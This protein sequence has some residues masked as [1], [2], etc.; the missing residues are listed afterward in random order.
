MPELDRPRILQLCAVDFTVWHFLMPLMR[1]QR[2]W[3]FDVHV[4]CTAGPFSERIE[5]EGFRLHP[6]SIR[7]SVNPAAH[8]K[9]YRALRRLLGETS[10]QMVHVHTPVAALIGRPAARR[11]GVPVVVY[12]AHGFY[13]HDRMGAMKRRV[14]IGLERWAQR[15]CDY[16]MTQSAE[17]C[18]TAIE[19]RI[20]PEA[21]AAVIGN[22]VD[23]DRFRPGGLD[24]AQ[25]AE[26]LEGLGIDPACGPIV[27]MMG[28]LVAEK[29]YFEFLEAWSTLIEEFPNARAI[30]IGEALQSDR[31]DSARAIGRRIED[32][33]L[34]DSIC[35]AGLR[36]DVPVLMG[37]SDLFVLPSWR[38][39]MP[40]SIIE[41]MASGAPVIATD[42]RGCREEVVDGETGRLVAPRDVRALAGALG[43]LM[44]DADLRRRMG[45]AGRRRAEAEFD[46]QIVL[47]RQRKIMRGLFEAKGLRWPEPPG[48][49]PNSS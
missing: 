46:E 9:S 22:G 48:A 37:A 23:L 41:A 6:L 4:A 25:R 30:I 17:D 44:R 11:S 40:R 16:L 8:L 3:G 28:R 35:F 31:E 10:F 19:E 39:G 27:T 36:D 15:Y 7:R 18:R 21:R 42:I 33:G 47:E 43:D 2:S 29:G 26:A 12:T 13:F 49:A 1:A 20:A 38:E 32:L 5:R 34:Q 45:E 24:G 14:H